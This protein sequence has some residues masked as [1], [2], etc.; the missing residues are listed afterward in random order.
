MAVEPLK[1]DKDKIARATYAS[2]RM[3]NRQMQW[4]R[5]A[6]WFD[7]VQSN[8]L[9]FPRVDHD[10]DVDAVSYF[11]VAATRIAGDPGIIQTMSLDEAH[12]LDELYGGVNEV[13]REHEFLGSR[14]LQL[15]GRPRF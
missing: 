1:A 11:A 10:D 15:R 14:L 12:D 13:I 2:I 3:R 4:P 8:M 6:L 5:G 9:A 7:E